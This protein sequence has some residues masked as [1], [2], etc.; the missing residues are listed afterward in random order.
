MNHYIVT[1]TAADQ[2]GIVHAVTG[3]IGARGGNVVELSQTVMKGYFTIILAVE[4]PEAVDPEVLRKA[5]AEDGRRFDL[6][7]VVREAGESMPPSPVP[8]GE[9]F[10]LTVLGPDKAG[11]IHSIAGC[12]A[13]NGVNIV[14][15]H[16]RVDG[17]I[18]SLVMEAY[19]PPDLP[20]S[21]VREELERFGRELGLEA[22][23]QHENIFLATTEPRPV[24][25]GPDRH[26]EG[27]AGVVPH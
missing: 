22:Y 8:D 13:E 12:L 21:T 23:V 16:A 27:A 11:S 25:V 17:P 9:K 26:P 19:L 18:F 3:T 24:R 2:V 7:V 6:T 5:V 1:V 10:I 20:P 14:D 15:L 4:F